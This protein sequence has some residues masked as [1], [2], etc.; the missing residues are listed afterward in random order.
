MVAKLGR[1]VGL[2]G[3]SKCFIHGDVRLTIEKTVRNT[4][5]ASYVIDGNRLMVIIIY[6]AQRH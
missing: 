3:Y 6:N 1:M 2:P 5:L 4:E